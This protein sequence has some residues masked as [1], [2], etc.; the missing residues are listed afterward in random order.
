M[1]IWPRQKRHARSIRLMHL[2]RGLSSS[3][4]AVA[5]SFRQLPVPLF[6]R[7]QPERPECGF[8][9]FMN[10]VAGPAYRVNNRDIESG[11]RILS[12]RAC[13]MVSHHGRQL[14]ARLVPACRRRSRFGATNIYQ[15]S[16]IAELDGV[17]PRRW[18]RHTLRCPD[19]V[20]TR[21]SGDSWLRPS[22]RRLTARHK[23]CAGGRRPG[24]VT[25]N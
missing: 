16:I 7:S 10:R 19:S 5:L 6:R 3:F 9:G 13:R 21:S 2:A 11:R 18:A 1:M 23:S 4:S 25:A 22:R 8:I 15:G 24:E 12:R 17:A 20:R 14:R